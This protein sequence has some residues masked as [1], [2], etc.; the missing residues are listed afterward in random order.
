MSRA[1]AWALTRRISPRAAVR[2]QDAADGKYGLTT[3]V[4]APLP[5][6]AWAIHLTDADHAYRLLG[7]DFDAKPG[8]GEKAGADLRDDQ[9]RARAHNDAQTLAGILTELRIE[10]VVCASGPSGGRHVWVAL[11]EQVPA[12]LVED[13][14]RAAGRLLPSLDIAPLCN[15]VTGALRPPGAPHRAGGASTPI[16]GD[17]EILCTPTVRREH[18]ETL[19]HRLVELAPAPAPPAPGSRLLPIEDGHDGHPRIPGTWRT[20]S[21]R[22]WELARAPLTVDV[23]ASARLFAVL[24]SAARAHWTLSDVQAQLA[25]L[26][27]LEHVRTVRGPDGHRVPRPRR[28]AGSPARILARNWSAAVAH[29]A[30]HARTDHAISH[31]D[32]DFDARAGELHAAVAHLDRK[33]DACMGRWARP[34]AAKDRLVLDALMLLALTT[35]RLDV[36]ASIRTLSR[37]TGICREGAWR[38]LHALEADGWIAL[39][40]PSEG[41]QAAVWRLLPWGLTEHG[42]HATAED[43]H[44]TP[45]IHSE[46]ITGV[47]LGGTAPDRPHPTLQKPTGSTLRATALASLTDRL[48]LSTHDAFTCERHDGLGTWTAL[49]YSRLSRSPQSLDRAF[50]AST[51]LDL[52]CAAVESLQGAGL[53]VVDEHGHVARTAGEARDSFAAHV[54][55]AGT[56]D[57]RAAE[58]ALESELWAWWIDESRWTTPGGRDP[59]SRPPRGA[60]A[61]RRPGQHTLAIG[62]PGWADRQPYPRRPGGRRDHRAARADLVADRTPVHPR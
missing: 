18:V 39:A 22:G 41:T 26:P 47:T 51:P 50:P 57:A 3:T 29:L 15:V 54:G 13:L 55:T 34:G 60:S 21:Q 5:A 62:Q 43:H 19:L 27:G 56:L 8:R 24:L 49:I 25:A 58:Y 14:A 2:Y 37:M 32:P 23:D 4:H 46:P 53:V 17:V 1:A 45:A 61:R 35:M 48:A 52:L 31:D 44:P 20:L 38:A 40:V 11:R 7:F 16:A 59:R 30:D 6:T 9:L 33:A 12:Q 28:G 36:G 42:D 10:H